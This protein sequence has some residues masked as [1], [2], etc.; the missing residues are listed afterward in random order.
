MV[1]IINLFKYFIKIF[2]QSFLQLFSKVNVKFMVI[3][4][5]VLNYIYLCGGPLLINGSTSKKERVK[6]NMGKLNEQVIKPS[7]VDLEAIM[8]TNFDDGEIIT[9]SSSNSSLGAVEKLVSLPTNAPIN[10]IVTKNP[11]PIPS[12]ER[13]PLSQTTIDRIDRFMM[14][15]DQRLMERIERRLIQQM[16]EAKITSLNPSRSR[17]KEVPLPL[18]EKV[19]ASKNIQKF[20]LD[21]TFS[22]FYNSVE[23]MLL[24]FYSKAADFFSVI[25]TKSSMLIHSLRSCYNPQLAADYYDKKRVVD[26]RKQD[27]QSFF[28]WLFDFC[29]GNWVLFLKLLIFFGLLMLFLAFFKSF[30]NFFRSM[31]KRKPPAVGFVPKEQPAFIK[32]IFRNTLKLKTKFKKPGVG[33]Y[34]IRVRLVRPVRAYEANNPRFQRFRRLLLRIISEFKTDK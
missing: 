32:K 11:V 24:D 4:N 29:S 13:T 22:N 31:F 5:Q 9:P 33:P 1:S 6:D 16:E 2:S 12:V 15:R 8:N 27:P 19:E 17:P 10:P 7:K 23:S 18:E 3:K 25:K 34:N 30:F 14:E 28:E 20:N 26:H 21:I